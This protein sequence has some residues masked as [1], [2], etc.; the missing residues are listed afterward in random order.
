MS[1]PES[2]SPSPVSVLASALIWVWAHPLHLSHIRLSS[3]RCCWPCVWGS[4]CPLHPVVLALWASVS[5]CAYSA[6]IFLPVFPEFSMCLS[7]CV[8]EAASYTFAL[9]LCYP[10]R[11]PVP[12]NAGFFSDCLSLLTGCLAWHQC[13][14][15]PLSFSALFSLLFL[16]LLCNLTYLLK[17][18]LSALFL[19]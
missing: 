10:H 15:L 18:G 9:I 19:L 16:F 14:S 6:L 7:A 11:E 1:S 3:F 4:S 17:N 12:C 2:S 5:L 13:S 8:S